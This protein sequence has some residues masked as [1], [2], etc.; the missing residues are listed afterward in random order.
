MRHE[1]R[2]IR[3]NPIRGSDKQKISSAGKSSACPRFASSPLK[4]RPALPFN[5]EIE[6]VIGHKSEHQPLVINAIT[7][8][9]TPGLDEPSGASSSRR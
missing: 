4:F 1:M 3:E 2:E 8:K 5:L 7:A 9:H 6:H